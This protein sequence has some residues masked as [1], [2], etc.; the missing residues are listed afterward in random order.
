MDGARRAI[1]WSRTAGCLET[2]MATAVKNRVGYDEDLY[3][4]TQKQAALLRARRTEGL[5]WDNLAEEIEWMAA[6]DRRELK[7][8][9]RV[10]LLHLLKWQAQPGKRGTSWR[11]SLR[12][13]RRRIRDLLE[14]S[15]SLGRHVPE[16]MR[17][18]YPDAVKDAVDE[19]GL[20]SERFPADC[21]YTPDEVLAEDHLPDASL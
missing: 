13:Q 18:V 15:P 11:K 6:R 17:A 5:D 14:E 20:P 4:W 7:N 3:A 8:R 16:L 19:T 2:T 12:N 9:L 21:P 10:I 1:L